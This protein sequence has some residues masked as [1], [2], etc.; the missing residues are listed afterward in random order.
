MSKSPR[1]WTDAA[2]SD[3]VAE[4]ALVRVDVTGQPV[5]L[6][7]QQGALSAVHGTCSHYGAPLVEGEVSGTGPDACLVCPWHGSRFRLRDGGVAQ[8]PATSPQLPFEV[9]EAGGR[10]QVRVRG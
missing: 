3:E 10:L 6:T 8:G 5:V 4:G 1:D 2:A 7:R 9:R